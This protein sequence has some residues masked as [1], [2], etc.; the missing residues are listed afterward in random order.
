[1]RLPEH[2]REAHRQAFRAMSL[3]QKLEY[4]FAYYKLPLVLVFIA[5]V[6]LGSVLNYQLTHKEP[7]LYVAYCNVG[8]PDEQDQELFDGFLASMGANPKT[9][10]SYRYYNLYLSEAEE[11]VDHQ[12]S[13]ASRLK[14]LAAVDAEELDVVFMNQGAY[15]LLSASGYLMDLSSTLAA[16]GTLQAQA[17]DLLTTNVV[18]LEDNR[19]EVELNEADT[20]EAVTQ[21][22]PNALDVTEALGGT[23]VLTGTVYLGIIGNTP[24][25]DTALSFV[26]YLLG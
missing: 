2:E 13:Y 18:V 7:V 21:E 14:T 5:A 26:S 4:I 24:R 25:L 8:L 16:S 1:M 6:A 19:L 15:D 12:Y 23:D 10:E 3:P 9:Q 17:N 11:S 22:V 20:Y